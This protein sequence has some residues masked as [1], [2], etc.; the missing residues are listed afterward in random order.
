MADMKRALLSI[1]LFAPGN[2]AVTN[3][4]AQSA[5]KFDDPDPQRY[6]ITARAS[7]IDPRV[8]AYPEIDFLIETEKG[9]PADLQHA[10]VDTSVAPR[11]KLV[12]WLMGHNKL[13]I[14]V[15]IAC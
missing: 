4:T 11:G 8:K 5:L 12:I 2:W 7:E 1:L 15:K 14:P 10:S 13:P 3:A 6:Q 9:A